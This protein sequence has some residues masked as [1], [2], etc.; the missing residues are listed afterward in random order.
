[1]SFPLSP[2]V[3]AT[4]TTNNITYI[5][6]VGSN[7][8]GYWTR[9]PIVITSST[10]GGGSGTVAS[11]T[12]TTTTF[13]IQNTTQ[14]T[15]TNSGALQVW[16]GAGIGGNLYVGG[17]IYQ[18]GVAVGTG[19]GGGGSS[20]GTT[21]SF[22]ITSQIQS[23][24]TT[25]GALVVSGGVGIGLNLNVGGIVS[26]GGVRTST[27][28]TTPQNPAVGDL[29]YNTLQDVT[30]RYTFDGSQTNWI[31]ITGPIA[32]VSTNTVVIKNTYQGFIMVFGG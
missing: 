18:N 2:T 27:T 8:V 9:L 19:G 10:S 30:Y 1:M 28:S 6:A 25:T 4:T 13:V 29:W 23:V 14:S 5:Y 31:D 7:G 21:S 16:G 26:G 3:G 32:V 11:G 22:L 20:T 15:G 24:S 17:T 12:G